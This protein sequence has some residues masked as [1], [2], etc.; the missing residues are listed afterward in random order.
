M[1][2]SLEEI[3]KWIVATGSKMHQWKHKK[4]AKSDF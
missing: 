4:L 3:K 1:F 2:Y